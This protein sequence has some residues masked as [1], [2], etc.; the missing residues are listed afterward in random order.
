MKK[1]L[2]FSIIALTLC[3]KS[4]AQ[5]PT[6]I[7]NFDST[8]TSEATY[9]RMYKNVGQGSSITLLK[10]TA[11]Q[12][13]VVLSNVNGYQSSVGFNL[14]TRNSVGGWDALNLEGKN[15]SVSL[16]VKATAAIT[17]L[18][19]QLTDTATPGKF[20]NKFFTIPAG[21]DFIKLEYTFTQEE[22]IA[23]TIN[24]RAIDGLQL[25][26]NPE[27]DPVNSTLT[28]DMLAV[29]SDVTTST[30]AREIN[31]NNI[32][33][34]NPSSDRVNFE[35]SLSQDGNVTVSLSDM[36]GKVITSYNNGNNN[37]VKGSF[38]VSGLE[39]GVY[40]LNY[41]VNGALANSELIIVK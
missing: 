11:S 21:N 4:I 12:L 18:R 31:T 38:D 35:T 19:V 36:V 15:V 2:L 33:Y 23:S 14:G 29:G 40:S 26:F 16:M 20:L 22:I 24:V 30:L 1:T 41:T 7:E 8:L 5:N 39:K 27:G 17:T 10:P 3:F 34:P 6:Y 13:A 9:P 37:L 25:N 28:F 32:L